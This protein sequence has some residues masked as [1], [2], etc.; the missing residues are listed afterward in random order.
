MYLDLYQAAF[1]ANSYKDIA[2]EV[3]K[4]MVRDSQKFVQNFSP[5][6]LT[7]AENLGSAEFHPPPPTTHR[8]LGLI[9]ILR[10]KKTPVLFLLD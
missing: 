1:M 5:L 6:W 8:I 3:L 7:E 9:I 10:F 4:F 2:N